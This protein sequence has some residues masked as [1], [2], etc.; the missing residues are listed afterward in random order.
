MMSGEEKIIGMLAVKIQVF[1]TLDDISTY[2][3]ELHEI[4]YGNTKKVFGYII[5]RSSDA[6]VEKKIEEFGIDKGLV[7]NQWSDFSKKFGLNANESVIANS[8]FVVDKE[9]IITYREIA[10]N[11]DL[12][13][14]E[15]NLTELI[16]Y[17]PKG[18]SHENWM[19]V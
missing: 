14:F 19:S 12:I 10:E 13:N 16:N 7:T 18:H 11:I 17:K 2:T 9:G 3:K 5:T 1:L 15:S 6:E 8:V 4:L